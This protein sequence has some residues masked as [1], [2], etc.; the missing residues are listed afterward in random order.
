MRLTYYGIMAR[1]LWVHCEAAGYIKGLNGM[2]DI[3]T[4]GSSESLQEI[5]KFIYLTNNV[6]NVRVKVVKKRNNGWCLHVIDSILAFPVCV[7]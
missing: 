3:A 7:Q 1:D 2:E 6:P 4:F 5:G